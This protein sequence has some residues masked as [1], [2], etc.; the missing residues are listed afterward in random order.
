MCFLKS[1][2]LIPVD[3][4][5]VRTYLCGRRTAGSFVCVAGCKSDHDD[6]EEPGS[7][8]S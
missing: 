8:G 2:H 7:Q 5:A 1:F 4:I 3:L 6:P